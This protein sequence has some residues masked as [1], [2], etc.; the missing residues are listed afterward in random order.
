MANGRIDILHTNAV[1]T[2]DE[3]S[4]QVISVTGG[5]PRVVAW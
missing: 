2:F 1:R 4:G 3:V 5:G